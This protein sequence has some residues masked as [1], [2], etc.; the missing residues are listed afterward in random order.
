MLVIS[1]QTERLCKRKDLGLLYGM[2]MRGACVK[3]MCVYT[4]RWEEHLSIHIPIFCI[5]PTSILRVCLSA[6]VWK[7]RGVFFI[8]TDSFYSALPNPHQE[9]AWLC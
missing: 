9:A 3:G 2:V 6:H 8:T 7:R 4:M 1:P 5:I